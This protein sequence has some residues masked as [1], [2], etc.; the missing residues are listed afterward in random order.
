MTSSEGACEVGAVA[1]FMI[2]RARKRKRRLTHLELQDLV[3]VAYGFYINLEDDALF[4]QDIEAKSYGPIV[5]ELYHEFK[6]FGV[7]PIPGWSRDFDYEKKKFNT[8]LVSKD[9]KPALRALNRTWIIYGEHFAIDRRTF[10]RQPGSP[11]HRAWVAKERTVRDEWI[12]EDFSEN[13]LERL[14]WDG[15][16]HKRLMR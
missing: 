3:Y 13:L 6:R 15:T 12:V 14:M 10:I 11:W 8:P 16:S 9:N 7:K 1:N 4:V 5:P 2:G